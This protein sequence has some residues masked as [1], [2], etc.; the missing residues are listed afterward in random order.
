[1]ALQVATGAALMCSF[2][3]APSVLNVIPAGVL[4]GALPAATI[5][6]HAP[7][8]NV[9]PFGL[10]SCLGNPA[11]AAATAA[12]LGA[13]TPMPCMP[14]TPAPWLPGSPTVLIGGK[15]ALQDASM[16][17]CAWGGVIRIT[18]PAQI[19]TTVP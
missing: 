4:A 3:A 17:M 7:V 19:T 9:A 13:L 1:M 8:V 12:A 15:P 6:D 2:G 18:A 14:A 5:M 11:V 16:L 10:C